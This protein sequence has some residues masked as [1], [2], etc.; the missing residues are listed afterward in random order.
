MPGDG[1]GD[2][3]ETIE[4]TDDQA[5]QQ[6]AEAEARRS[7]WRPKDEWRGDP[8]QWVPAEEFNRRGK[9]ILPI[10]QRDLRQSRDDNA[11]LKRQVADLQ[12]NF[13]E[14]S[15]TLKE[16]LE[17]SRGSEKRGYERAK[18][19]LEARAREA[20]STGDTASYDDA[21]AALDQLKP[22]AE[23]APPPP[24][25]KRDAPPPN[26]DPAVIA[27][28][29]ANP[30]FNTD[31]VLNAAMQ[32]EHTRLLAEAPGL[33]LAENLERAKAAV[34]EQFP[35]KFGITPRTP[36]SEPDDDDNPEPARQ[37]VTQRRTPVSRPSTTVPG[38]EVDTT[39]IA[40]IADPQERASARQAFERF[41]RSIPDYTEAEYMAS[42]NDPHAD[43]LG[44]RTGKKA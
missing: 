14:Q 6:A 19:E 40:S 27:F 26:V 1:E 3:I 5:D 29:D 36:Q 24:P 41:K 12:R 43:V 21:K 2:T 32:E 34:V 25:P 44:S 38:R 37:P 10:V 4:P 22:P 30:W 18:R 23:V 9:D 15:L 16:L 42:Y 8:R 17:M 7:G 39:K 33:S 11:V 35:R 20:A 13:D 28:V 31:R